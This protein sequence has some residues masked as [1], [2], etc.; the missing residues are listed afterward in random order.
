M[1]VKE[2]ME[3][4]GLSRKT[5]TEKV[6]LFFPDIVNNGKAIE[7]NETQAIQVMDDLRKKGFITPA[8][9]S[10][11]PTQ[12][13]QDNKSLISEIV[14]DTLSAIMPVMMETFKSIYRENNQPV[15]QKI[16]LLPALEY[17]T[18]LAYARSIGMAGLT[19]AQLSSWGKSCS[20][21]S[22]EMGIEIR[23]IESEKYGP[24]GSYRVDVLKTVIRGK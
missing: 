1:T 21:V 7:L 12:N 20:T 14:K 3:I 24:I 17:M 5:I 15:Q 9:N 16:E 13:S 23:K 2:L 22:R 10:Q 19:N 18:C 4:T 8:K 6:K 11:V